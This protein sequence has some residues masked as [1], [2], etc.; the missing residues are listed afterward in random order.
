MTNRPDRS[1]VPH[2]DLALRSL[3]ARIGQELDALAQLCAK[4]QLALSLCQ[5]SDHTAPEAICGLQG[6][7]R[8]TQTL[9]DLGRVM[10]ALSAEV[11]PDAKV[12]ARPILS[13]L[14][15][16]DLVCALMPDDITAGRPRSAAG[17]VQW[18]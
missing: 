15:L 6:L 17:E 11:P 18:F 8:I 13:R 1:D 3:A 12:Q 14:V 9:E 7:D 16:H 2:H 10:G 5:F 4:V